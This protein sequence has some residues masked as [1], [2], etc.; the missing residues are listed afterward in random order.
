MS[1]ST[2]IINTLL[3]LALAVPGYLLTKLKM[4]DGSVQTLEILAMKSGRK[5]S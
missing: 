1:F 5:Q 2:V 3:L 4:A